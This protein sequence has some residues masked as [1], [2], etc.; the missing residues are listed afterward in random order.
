MDQCPSCDQPL[1]AS[2]AVCACGWERPQVRATKRSGLHFA[3][4]PPLTK[5]QKQA[6][7]RMGLKPKPGETKAEYAARNRQWI[8][9]SGYAPTW[10]KRLAE[11]E[12]QFN[13][14]TD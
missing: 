7:T 2:Q 11:Q 5:A 6:L 8:I 9:D 3:K 12:E 14:K 13:G 10:A 4:P 1:H